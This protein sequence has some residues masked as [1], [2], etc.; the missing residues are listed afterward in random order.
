MIDFPVSIRWGPA[1]GPEF[2]YVVDGDGVTT[3]VPTIVQAIAETRAG[4]G[5]YSARIAID[6][7]WGSVK[8]YWS[9]AD[10][11]DGYAGDGP[12]SVNVTATN[13]E[14]IIP[15][16]GGG[17]VGS[18]DTS[19]NQDGAAGVTVNGAASATDCMQV[20]DE[21]GAEVDRAEIAAYLKSDYDA[22]HKGPAFRQAFV[23]TGSDG[24][25]VE[26]MHLDA[27]V[28]TFEAAADQ[29]GVVTFDVVVP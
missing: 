4:S 8:D 11:M 20:V 24:R 22:G 6:P 2:I 17:G 18:G 25:W 13:F 26:S 1:P 28:Y 27:G 16:A 21:N 19:I 7:A 23:Q 10:G 5:V 14:P 3:H 12:P 9:V 29:L 15:D